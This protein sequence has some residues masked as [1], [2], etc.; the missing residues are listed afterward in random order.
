MQA[1]LTLDRNILLWIQDNLRN[2][3]LTAILR[4]ITHLADYGA[5]W[6]L[7]TF[8]LLMIKKT[9]KA[10]ICCAC[11]LIVMAV[12]NSLVIKNLVDRQRP[13]EVIEGLEILVREPW[14]SSF[15]SGHTASSFA[16]TA[17]LW[18]SL[19]MVMDK[20]KA[21][22]FAVLALILSI[23]IGFS[24]IYTGVHHV[25]DVLAGLVLGIIYGIAGYYLGRW[26]IRKVEERQGG[27]STV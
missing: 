8:I 19:P 20:K 7:L 24:R 27:G 2:P 11:A 25:S 1:I 26:V 13:Y 14:D 3:F 21:R 16:M 5:I 22:V 15:P 17:A 18:L 10:G 9:R 23:L 4:P 12:L 6:I